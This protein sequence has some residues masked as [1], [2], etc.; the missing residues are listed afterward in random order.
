MTSRARSSGSRPRFDADRGDRRNALLNLGLLLV[1]IA[2]VLLLVVAIALTWYNGHLV[3]AA[4]VDGQSISKD[5]QTEQATVDLLRIE[6]QERT[7]RT[8][9]VAG[10]IRETDFQSREAL[11]GQQK[12]NIGTL[13]LEHLIDG[14]IQAGLLAQQGGTVTDADVDA[15]LTELATSPEIRHAWIIEV[16]PELSTG[17]ATPTDAQKAA[18]K[19]KADRALADLKAGKGW[20]EVAK[21]VSTSSTKEQGG[22]VGYIDDKAINLDETYLTAIFAVAPN[23]PTDVLE[24]KDGTF[25]IGRV[26][27][28]IP[29]AVD[30]AYQQKVIDKGVSLPAFRN[31]VRMDVVRDRLEKGLVDR[32]TAVGPQ[33]HVEEIFMRAGQSE[34]KTGALRTKHI[35]YAPNDDPNNASSVPDTDPAWAAAE[36]AARD[37]YALIKADPSKFDAIARA[38]SDENGAETTG[39]KLPYFAPDDPIDPAFA[40]AIFKSGLTD[41]QLL[42][43]VKSSFGWHVIMIWHKPTDLDWAKKL[44]GDLGSGA[45]F[46]TVAR[47]NSDGTEAKDGGDI[48]WVP[49]GLLPQAVNAAIFGAPVGG[50]TEPLVVVADGKSAADAGVYLFKVEAEENR[51]PTAEE[52]AKIERSAFATWYT[53]QKAKATITRPDTTSD[54]LTQ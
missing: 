39:G 52:K 18:A 26:T 5:Q 51:A 4:S 47:N 27:Q 16:A 24:G 54:Q 9:H 21:A 20:E 11:L 19:A 38:E 36:K 14:R 6:L 43:P 13:A 17:A 41:G 44:K 42:E 50:V 15:K 10:T 34:T 29:K 53:E 25:R 23:A 37:A 30:A 46:K 1:V 28:V 22:D 45:D 7:L 35:L 31:V 2:A 8:R 3:A 40:N 32:L 12:S 33:R 48:G 49:N